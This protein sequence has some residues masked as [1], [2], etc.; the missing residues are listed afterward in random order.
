M[1]SKKLKIIFRNIISIHLTVTNK[2]QAYK[3][4]FEA[5][6][7]KFTMKKALSRVVRDPDYS[8][9]EEYKRVVEIIF[10]EYGNNEEAA[11]IASGYLAE[12]FDQTSN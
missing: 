2:M 12:Y 11:I 5:P 3:F 4:D 1:D 8:V 7:S 6:V 9:E 10:S